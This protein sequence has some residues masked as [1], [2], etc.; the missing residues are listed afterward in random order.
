[1]TN[2]HSFLSFTCH[3]INSDFE[4]RQAVLNIKHFP[5][6]HNSENINELLLNVLDIWNLKEKVHLFKQ[7]NSSNMVKGITDAV[8]SAIS[9]FIHTLKLVVKDSLKIQRSVNDVIAK[10]Y[11]IF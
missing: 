4:S 2:N 3:W 6:S 9:C 8:F 1:M 5:S 7:D 11:K 10:C